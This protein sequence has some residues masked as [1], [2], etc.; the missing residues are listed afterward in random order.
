M[1]LVSLI[2]DIPSVVEGFVKTA[3]LIV[4][5]RELESK[6][7]GIIVDA[8]YYADKLA[9]FTNFIDGANLSEA[10][11][12]NNTGQRQRVWSKVMTVP[13]KRE[14]RRRYISDDALSSESQRIL[15][16]LFQ[17][18]TTAVKVAQKIVYE[19]AIRLGLIES[20]S[21]RML[22]ARLALAMSDRLVGVPA[23]ERQKRFFSKFRSRTAYLALGCIQIEDAIGRLRHWLS[24][25]HDMLL[26]SPKLYSRV[27]MSSNSP[28]NPP[29]KDDDLLFVAL[30]RD[31]E[32]R[33]CPVRQ[34]E[35]DLSIS[36]EPLERGNEELL[37]VSE[38]PFEGCLLDRRNVSHFLEQGKEDQALKD[39]LRMVRLFSEEYDDLGHN[40]TASVGILPCCGYSISS[41]GY[42][43]FIFR[44]P[45]CYQT[46]CSLRSLLLEEPRHSLNDRVEFC[47]KLASA[48]L[49]VHSLGL[50]HKDIRPDSV[51][52]LNPSFQR[53]PDSATQALGEP[54]LVSFS[55]SRS[56][57][58]RTVPVTE[59]LRELRKK[60]WVA[61][62]QHPRH[63]STSEHLPYETRDD[64]FSLGI[65]LLE[66][67]IWKSL[68][69]WDEERELFDCDKTVLDF[70]PEKYRSELD[71]CKAPTR[72]RP[73]LRRR[74]LIK[75][76]QEKVPVAMGTTF[77]DVVV[78]CL[79]FGE[80]NRNIADMAERQKDNVAF[81]QNQSINFVRHVL[82]RLRGL[83]LH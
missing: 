22:I 70:T 15:L 7:R 48:V 64:V 67:G 35:K 16:D 39:T 43:D 59:A 4:A 2:A 14:D 51:L 68:F 47:I 62:Y 50:V 8:I 9:Y 10:N 82:T 18:A 13:A 11:S 52:V 27:L 75:F 71:G 41:P 77:R 21:G 24:E 55:Q 23:S 33:T 61:L 81:L 42:H 32:S 63:L 36:G 54:Y 79:T 80:Q 65:C 66:I 26:A 6:Y 72:F 20:I 19:W 69:V 29:G 1:D 25:L 74:D 37:V 31:R 76:A 56:Q 60:L 28:A 53:N 34:I 5:C 83:K 58:S 12:D 78:D 46:S 40:I 57:S 30:A 3:R 17:K 73:G 38:G 44:I 49:I 45:S